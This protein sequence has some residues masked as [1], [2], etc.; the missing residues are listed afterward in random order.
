MAEGSRENVWLDINLHKP[1][2]ALVDSFKLWPL[3]LSAVLMKVLQHDIIY[4]REEYVAVVVLH[5]Q[6]D[7]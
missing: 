6:L 1:A 7:S 5:E 2:E 4:I 3:F